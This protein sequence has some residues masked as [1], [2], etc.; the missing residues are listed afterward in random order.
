MRARKHRPEQIISILR[1]AETSELSLADFCRQKSIS[2]ETFYR[3]RRRY[4]G[5]E[6]SDAKQLRELA[7]ENTRLK[8]LLAERGLE[9]DALKRLMEKNC[10]PGP[11]AGRGPVP[12]RR[13]AIAAAQLRPGG[14]E[15]LNAALP[16]KG[17]G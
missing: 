7:D 17:A 4:S 6:V 3:W 13:R 16:A 15:P 2:E 5:M 1:E 12:D 10:E 14:L 11:A 9:V 8:Q